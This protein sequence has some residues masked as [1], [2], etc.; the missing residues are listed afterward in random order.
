LA[1]APGTRLGVYEITAQIGEGGMGQVFRATDTKLKRHVAIKI[2]PPSL[3]ADADRLARFQREAEVLASLNH[4]NIAGIYGLEEGGGTTALVMELVEGEDL[5]QRIARGAVPLD[6]ALPIAKQ[7]A[8]ALEAAHEQG[9]VH[10]DLKPANIKV[11]GDGT[12]KV[13]DFGL[14]KAM[15][16]AAG[17]SSGMSMSPTL[18]LHA[19]QAGIILGTAAYMAPEQARGKAADRRADIWAFGVILFE[20]ISGT[21]AFDGETI[22]DVLAKVIEREPDW[23]RLPSSTPPSLGALLRRCLR[24]DPKMRLQAIGDARLELQELIDGRETAVALA[25]P[26]AAGGARTLWIGLLTGSAITLAIVMMVLLGLS[27]RVSAPEPAMTTRF[28]YALP[29]EWS[30]SGDQAPGGAT[31]P[32][33]ISP[34]GRRIAFVARTADGRNSLWVRSLN[35]LDA[36]QVPRT[37]GAIAPFWSPDGR[38]VGFFAD[39]KLKKV[40]ALGG[41]PATIC[42]AAAFRGA[43]WNF[44]D[45]IVFATSIGGLKRVAAAGGIPTDLTQVQGDEVYHTRPVF[46][47]HSR[48]FLY[49]VMPKGGTYAASLDSRER[50]LVLKESD[51][52]N[53][54]ISDGHLLFVRGTTLMA[55]RFDA[56]R[57]QVLGEAFPVVEQIA[58][59]TPPG[60]SNQIGIFSASYNGV[61]TYQAGATAPPRLTWI[62]RAGRQT[63][64]VGDAA[65]YRSVSLSPDA[66]QA[67]VFILDESQQ[68]TDV[69]IVDVVRGQRSRFTF[70]PA[71]DESPVWAA[72]GSRITFSSRR[73]RFADLY[74]RPS[75]QT[76]AEHVLLGSEIDKMPWSWSHDGRFLLFGVRSST[77]NDVWVLPTTGDKKPF[78]FLNAPY[79]QTFA[80]FSPDGRWVAYTSNETGRPQVFV[81]PFPGPGG[82]WMVSRSGGSMARWRADGKELFFLDGAALQAIEVNGDNA[83]FE[84]GTPHELFNANLSMSPRY[85]Y[86]VAPDGKRFLVVTNGTAPSALPITVVLNWHQPNAR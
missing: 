10:R 28:T 29:E 37:E 81:V 54:A 3:A 69:W 13:L 82:K 25:D 76:E 31:V 45:V 9:I 59:Q 27:Y 64:I 40:D 16:P 23:S 83:R 43:T 12:V 30:V 80:Q 8:E 63:G 7:I 14:A 84:Y 50:T 36:Q 17:S 66:K 52:T 44:E 41:A 21:R 68:N 34:D 72:D 70:D 49:R 15:E 74:E 85:L 6:E 53:I 19:T 26:P 48:R 56:D 18:S 5:S 4:P 67:A 78:A 32:L 20:L 58:M 62:D 86:D 55:Q 61:L 38:F 22:S 77:G 60:G 65:P 47:P 24:K 57:L 71:S 33:S 1:L 79:T 46:L 11:R 2:L 51:S 39:G 75:S 73:R 42:D 35:A